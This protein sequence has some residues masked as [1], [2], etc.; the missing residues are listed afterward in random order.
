MNTRHKTTA[1]I[2]SLVLVV[3]AFPAVEKQAIRQS[4]PS[5]NASSDT[6][7]LCLKAWVP[8]NSYIIDLCI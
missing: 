7:W 1:L 4:P 8:G 6:K 3:A 2:L 5:D